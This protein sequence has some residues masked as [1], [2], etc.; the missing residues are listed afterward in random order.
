MYKRQA[1]NVAP[2]QNAPG[3]ISNFRTTTN[4]LTIGGVASGTTSYLQDGVPN[5][6][7]L[8]KTANFQPT[9]EAVQEVSILSLIHI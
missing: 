1:T 2:F 7:V 3:P 8:T 6:A 4:S 9:I 5:I